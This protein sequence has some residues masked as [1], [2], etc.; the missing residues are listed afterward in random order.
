MSRAMTASP[1]PDSPDAAARPLLRA[2]RAQRPLRAGSLLITLFGDAIAPRGG[3][4]ALSSMITLAGQFGL[5]ER[6]V[7]TSVGRLARENWLQCERIGRLSYYRLTP[8]GRAEFASATQRIYGTAPQ[9]WEGVWTVVLMGELS[10]AEREPLSRDF[11]W[12]GF[13]QLSPG[14]LIYPADRLQEIEPELAASPEG[15]RVLLLQARTGDRARDLR[16]VR[17]GW[18]LAEL[19]QRYR[20]LTRLLD[21]VERALARGPVSPA[22]SFVVR[23]LLVHEYRRIHLRDPLLPADLLPERWT[24]TEVAQRCGHIYRAVF[25]GAERFL[26]AHAVNR[27]GRVPPAGPESL[28]RFG[29]LAPSA[30]GRPAERALG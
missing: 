5:S 16:L 3:E 14:V 25:A 24:G 19:E 9:A 23:T 26:N 27:A 12:R 17:R 6:L 4:I 1:E 18:D 28:R 30:G 10:P 8:H 11:R 21:P 13:G 7:R 29:G 15:E 2:F 22:T 20:R